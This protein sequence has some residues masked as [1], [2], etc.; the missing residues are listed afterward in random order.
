[1]KYTQPDLSDC[2]EQRIVWW[3]GYRYEAVSLDDSLPQV[4]VKPASS[5]LVEW[6]PTQLSAKDS[7]RSPFVVVG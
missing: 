5:V 2:A 6:T 4:K 1:M 7:L 3:S